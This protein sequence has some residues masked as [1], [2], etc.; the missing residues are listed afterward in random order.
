[1]SKLEL[2]NAFDNRIKS[3]FS[4]ADYLAFASS[5]NDVAPT[6]IRIHP[7]KNKKDRLAEQV[8]WCDLGYYLPERPKFTLDPLFHAGAYYVQEAS[9]MFIWHILQQI[10]DKKDSLKILDLCAAPGGKSSLIASFLQNNG[11]LVANEVIKNRAYTLKYNLSKEGYSNV[12]V[13]NN[14]PKE[15]GQII[16]FFDIILIDAPCSGEGMFRKDHNAACE[17]SEDN[18]NNCAA[19]Q[20]R[21]IA[22]VLPSLKNGGH[23]IYSTCTYN[24]DENI[25]NVAWAEQL[26]LASLKIQQPTAWDVEEVCE[27]NHVGYQFYPHK[28]KGEGFFVSVMQKEDSISN[29][30]TKRYKWVKNLD[31]LDKKLIPIAKEWVQ[32]TDNMFFTDKMGTVHL[33]NNENYEHA[34]LLSQHLRLIYVG[35]HIGQ[36]NKNIIVP[37][38]SLSL[39]MC[40]HSAIP[41]VDLSL[42]DALLYLK[43][44]LHSIESNDRSWLLATY[45]GLGIGWLKNL[46]NRINNYLPNEHKILMKLELD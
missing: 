7:I 45:Q 42:Y 19:R 27:H 14:D 38:H 10:V 8:A 20:K 39:S 16:D 44:E 29:N 37:D 36:V 25:K 34:L 43:K 40:V 21:I 4:E 22:D 33:T 2:P 31:P 5:L 17:W 18:V 32:P 30:E 9:S 26:G 35:I 6:S 3:S 15:I 13:T 41:T 12:M 1:M 28:T 24:D 11:I 46:G 23:M